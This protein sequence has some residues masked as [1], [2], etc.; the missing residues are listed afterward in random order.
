ML[1]NRLTPP[2]SHNHGAAASAARA[3]FPKAW[4]WRGACAHTSPPGARVNLWACVG[5]RPAGAAEAERKCSLEPGGSCL[6]HPLFAP[7]FLLGRK[8]W[9]PGCVLASA[10]S[11]QSCRTLCNPMDCG[12]PGSSVH[13]ISQAK[14]LE[15]VAISSSRES[16]QPRDQ[17]PVS[18]I[19]YVG[20]QILYH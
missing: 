1:R 5:C 18:C 16:S 8:D 4:Q 11:F 20:R 3:W 13:G 7:P 14:I 12:P 19:F 17:T 2:V 9:A 10:K 15:C 6:E